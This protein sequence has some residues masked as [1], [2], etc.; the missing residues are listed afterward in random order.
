MD[1]SKKFF[2]ILPNRYNIINNALLW[3]YC[4]LGLRNTS[5]NKNYS[6]NV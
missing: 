1:F 4:Y 5:I 3:C 6:I 2:F